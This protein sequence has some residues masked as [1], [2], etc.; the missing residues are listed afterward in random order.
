MGRE[1]QKNQT[2]KSEAQKN[3]IGHSPSPDAPHVQAHGNRY[4]STNTRLRRV[5]ARMGHLCLDSG[6]FYFFVSSC[7]FSLLVLKQGVML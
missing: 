6:H 3:Q 1:A 7:L 5:F 2:A 4:K